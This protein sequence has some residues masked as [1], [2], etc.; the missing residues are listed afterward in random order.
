MN[1]KLLLIVLH[2]IQGNFNIYLN[3]LSSGGTCEVKFIVWTDDIAISSNLN[4]LKLKYIYYIV[5]FIIRATSLVDSSLFS[6]FIKG[7]G[8]WI[9]LKEG[10]IKL[11]CSA[12]HYSYKHEKR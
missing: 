7:R 3:V 2:S 9:S 8:F 1:M 11:G 5:T 6:L 10:S 12:D 4:K